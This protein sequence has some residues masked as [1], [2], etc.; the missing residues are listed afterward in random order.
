MSLDKDILDDFVVESKKL[1]ED[2][3]EIL[4]EVEGHPDQ[5]ARLAEYGNLVDRIMGGARSLSLLASKDHAIHMISD[6]AAVCKAVGYK[7]S[8][9]IENDSFYSACVG[10]LLDATENLEKL[11]DGVETPTSELKKEISDTF[12]DR[13]QWV[14]KRFS[15]DVRASVSASTSTSLNPADSMSQDSIDDL[16]KKLG[17][18]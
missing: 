12:I 18:G 8:Q 15:K 1:V 5:V 16:L 7:S 10:L 3:L 13:L 11:L 4:N 9:I 14:S 17:I 2:S 6:Y